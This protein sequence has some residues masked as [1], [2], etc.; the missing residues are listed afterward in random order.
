MK[1]AATASA[2]AARS[3]AELGAK[4]AAE[5]ARLV[6]QLDGRLHA[7]RALKDR[8]AEVE[9]ELR[10]LRRHEGT[11]P[12]GPHAEAVELMQASC[13]IHV[14]EE[15]ARLRDAREA[16]Q[17]AEL[18]AALAHAVGLVRLSSMF[19]KHQTACHL[20]HTLFVGRRSRGCCAG[21]QGA[22]VYSR[23]GWAGADGNPSAG[24]HQG[25]R[26]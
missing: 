11:G 17:R 23:G 10:Q 19:H 4:T 22:P 25:P 12:S 16:A 24:P 9:A 18:Q 3:G 8:L 15:A 2:I 6:L 14:Q 5:L 21:G 20:S 7:F 26:R 1:K 13:G